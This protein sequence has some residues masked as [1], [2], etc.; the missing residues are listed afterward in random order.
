MIARWMLFVI[1]SPSGV[2]KVSFFPLFLAGV[3]SSGIARS[4]NTLDRRVRKGNQAAANC[5]LWQ[6]RG[7]PKGRR[8]IEEKTASAIFMGIE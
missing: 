5:I 3:V 4:Q 2:G 1:A 8:L 6:W 7:Q